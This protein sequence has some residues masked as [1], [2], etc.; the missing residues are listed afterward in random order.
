MTRNTKD[1]VRQL[2]EKASGVSADSFD[3]RKP[4]AAQ[5]PVATY[6]R[7]TQPAPTPRPPQLGRP[8]RF[9]FV[10]PE[11]TKPLW[12]MD[13]AAMDYETKGVPGRPPYELM[14]DDWTELEKVVVTRS[15]TFDKFCQQVCL[16]PLVENYDPEYAAVA[17]LFLRKK[18]E[19]QYR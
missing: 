2:A 14:A 3:T 13:K 12:P 7:P 15:M 9:G 19:A 5:A 4:A 10:P 16:P 17:R 11:P 1:I 8:N 6:T 18:R